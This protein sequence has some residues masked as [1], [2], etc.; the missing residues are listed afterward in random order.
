MSAL[1]NGPLTVTWRQGSTERSGCFM[2]GRRGR[3]IRY[4]H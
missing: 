1:L 4:D 2:V 3:D